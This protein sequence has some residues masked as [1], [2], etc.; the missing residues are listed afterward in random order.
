MCLAAICFASALSSFQNAGVKRNV[1]AARQS[2]AQQGSSRA[3]SSARESHNCSRQKRREHE[4]GLEAGL[5][6]F[7]FVNK[8]ARTG[9]YESSIPAIIRMQRGRIP[10]RIRP[11]RRDI[12]HPID[13]C[14]LYPYARN[15]EL[16]VD[17]L[18][19]PLE[20]QQDYQGVLH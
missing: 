8:P 1:L 14:K 13:V 7:P 5:R 9:H 18:A 4:L 6:S 12:V 19:R 20:I 3:S 11:I 2:F 16:H 17:G 15:P 10:G